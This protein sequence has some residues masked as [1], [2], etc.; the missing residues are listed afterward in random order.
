MEI[1]F[2]GTG[3]G[4]V[5]LSTQLRSTGGILFKTKKHQIHID[6][7]PGAL[8]RMRILKKD[9]RK[10][11]IVCLSHRHTDHVGDIWAI[12]ES[13]NQG[14][15]VAEKSC[16]KGKESILSD[17]YKQFYKKIYG[18]EHGENVEIDGLHIKTTKTKHEVNAVGFIIQEGNIKVGYSGDTGYFK[19]LGKEYE[20][21][22]I[23]I[24]NVLRPQGEPLKKHLCTDEVIEILKNMKKK[25]KNVIITHFG[26]KML[27][28]GPLNQA[29]VISLETGVPCRAA[30]D[31]MNFMVEDVLEQ[32]TL[33]GGK[34][35]T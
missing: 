18:L 7:G 3:G 25:P 15:L 30:H 1:L 24:L 34:Y 14:Y 12:S 22:E 2:L 10:T 33:F 27:R 19:T 16:V 11:D 20:G 31:G 35:K 6:P 4:R 13:I 23:L 17:W 28:A 5:V 8:L 26:M 29:R 9:P 21:V 32:S